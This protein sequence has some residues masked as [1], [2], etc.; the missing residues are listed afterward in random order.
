MAFLYGVIALIA[1]SVGFTL[2]A[3]SAYQKSWGLNGVAF[4]LIM[5]AYVLMVM[6][7]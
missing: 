2:G 1:A 4:G 5:G 7:P 3:V 6:Q